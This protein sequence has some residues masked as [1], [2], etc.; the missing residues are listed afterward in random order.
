MKKENE[1]MAK[2]TKAKAEAADEPVVEKKAAKAK[3]PS[4]KAIALANDVLLEVLGRPPTETELTTWAL[5]VDE[6]GWNYPSLVVQVK[7][8]MRAL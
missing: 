1:T 6:N 4:S 2:K 7:S 5:K 3:G 8:G